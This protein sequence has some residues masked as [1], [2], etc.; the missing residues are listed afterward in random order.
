ML[1]VRVPDMV[2]SA[3]AVF[4]WQKGDSN[5][6]ADGLK[7]QAL[8][9]AQ[10]YREHHEREVQCVF[11]RVQHHWHL[12]DKRT[13]KRV[14]DEVLSTQGTRRSEKREARVQKWFSPQG[15]SRYQQ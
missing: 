4:L 6:S 3:D 12:K 2:S 10:K 14:P 11:S 13:G 7:E 5:I 9:E 1:G 8:L 15:P